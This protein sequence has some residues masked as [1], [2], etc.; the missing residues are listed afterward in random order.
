MATPIHGKRYA[1]L[2]NSVSIC[3]ATAGLTV[4]QDSAEVTTSCSTSKAFL[5]GKYGWTST[6]AGPADFADNAADETLFNAATASAAYTW[7]IEP[8]GPSAQSATNPLYNGSAFVTSYGLSFDQ[9]A[10]VTYSAA[11]Q[12]TGALTRSVA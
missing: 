4:T 8:D 9:G 6:S 7:S 3:S 12:G 2:F 10:A 1:E 11:Y 5:P